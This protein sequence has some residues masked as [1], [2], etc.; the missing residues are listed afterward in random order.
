MV[1]FG[2]FILPHVLQI[3][4]ALSRSEI[5]RDVPKRQIAYRIDHADLGQE[6]R[7]SG[8]I[9]ETTIS[10]VFHVIER[11]RRFCDGT[12]RELDI[13]D[14]TTPPFNALLADPEFEF[15]VELWGR[16]PYTVTLLQ[17]A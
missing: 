10:E 13:Q 4:I 17:V 6:V 9:R 7:V 3:D 8:E 12:A 1:R 11:I 16:V 15:N 2:N 5:E 14:A